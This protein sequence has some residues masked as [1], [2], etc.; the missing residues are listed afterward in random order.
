[1]AGHTRAVRPNPAAI[2]PY[3]KAVAFTHQIYQIQPVLFTILEISMPHLSLPFGTL[4]TA[5]QISGPKLYCVCV[6]I[7]S[8]GVHKVS[9]VVHQGCPHKNPQNTFSLSHVL[10]SENMFSSFSAPLWKDCWPKQLR[11]IT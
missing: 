9:S 1:M 6:E 11:Q 3:R 7:L 8:S 10:N 2:V 5:F 4:Q